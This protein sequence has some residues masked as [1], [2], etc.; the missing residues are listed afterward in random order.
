MVAFVNAAGVAAAAAVDNEEGTE[1]LI[2]VA[3]A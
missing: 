1:I 3:A 2:A